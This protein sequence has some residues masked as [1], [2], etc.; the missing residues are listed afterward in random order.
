V[1]EGGGIEPLALNHP[2]FQD[3]L[4]AIQR[5]LPIEKMAVGAGIEL[6]RLPSTLA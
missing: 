3:R 6:A 1:E 4:P 5:H 2:G